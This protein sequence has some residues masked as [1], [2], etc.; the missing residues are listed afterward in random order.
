MA[1]VK[2]QIKAPT[3]EL[4]DEKTTNLLDAESKTLILTE[5]VEYGCKI[6]EKVKAIQNEVKI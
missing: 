4:R 6:E 5:M 1:Q 2:E 3:R